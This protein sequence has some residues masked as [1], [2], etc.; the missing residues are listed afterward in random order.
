MVDTFFGLNT[1]EMC[2][3]SGTR[4]Q[5]MYVCS[6]ACFTPHDVP[7]HVTLVY[8]L[9][10]RFYALVQDGLF[11]HYMANYPYPELRWLDLW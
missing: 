3:C 10:S 8:L 6:A 1:I 5:A 11:S 2:L 7:L 4:R 9:S